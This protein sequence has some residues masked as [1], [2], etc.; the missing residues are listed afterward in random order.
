M[1]CQQMLRPLM[2][3]A[4]T[5][6]VGVVGCSKSSSEQT[7]MAIYN[8]AKA[9]EDEGRRL[10]AL[11]EFDRLIDFKDTKVFS[12]ADAALSREGIS[13]GSA[14]ESWT[15]KRMFEV[16]NRVIRE[17]RERHP[18]GNV[19]VPYGV[20]DAWGKPLMIEYSRGP[21]YT[22]VVISSGKDKTLDTDDDLKLYRGIGNGR[23]V[24]GAGPHVGTNRVARVEPASA[25][26]PSAAETVVDL[27]DLLEN[28]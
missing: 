13:I 2:I 20:N 10:D 4:I 8:K 12:M 26:S 27:K 28:Q 9:L 5:A 15:L 11:R 7:A 19:T 17:G 21:K 24:P 22:F 18:D 16:K 25:G 1:K 6:V 3:M 23:A 14:L